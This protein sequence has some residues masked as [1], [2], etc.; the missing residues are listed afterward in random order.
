MTLFNLLLHN[1]LQDLKR[2]YDMIQEQLTQKHLE[3]PNWYL[4]MYQECLDRSADDDNNDNRMSPSEPKT[5][6]YRLN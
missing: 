6:H 1:Y 2:I 4:L 3:D 5:S